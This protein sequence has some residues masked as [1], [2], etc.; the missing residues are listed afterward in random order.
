MAK[1][2]QTPSLAIRPAYSALRVQSD[3]GTG[4]SCQDAINGKKL[5]KNRIVAYTFIHLRVEEE[6]ANK[7]GR[8]RWEVVELEMLLNNADMTRGND[9]LSILVNGL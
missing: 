4:T 3:L 8:G 5:C 9:L 1:T 6:V 2:A 7:S